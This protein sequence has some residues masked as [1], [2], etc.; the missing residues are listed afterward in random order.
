[1]EGKTKTADDILNSK[2]RGLFKFEIL[3][4]MEIYAEQ[5]REKA[6]REFKDKLINE[7][8]EGN[9]IDTSYVYYAELVGLI[10]NLK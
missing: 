10:E 1:M 6:V 8:S 4:A 9:S 2:S 7:I 3:E 5:E